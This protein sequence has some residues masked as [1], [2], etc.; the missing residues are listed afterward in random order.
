MSKLLT[1]LIA[2]SF[3]VGLNFAAAQN[4]DSDK[5]KAQGQEKVMQEKEQ[6]AQQNSSGAP[7]GQSDRERMRG[8]AAQ[9]GNPQNQSGQSSQGGRNAQYSRMTQECRSMSGADK[10]QCMT[11]AR[12]RYMSSAASRCGR[13]TDASMKQQCMDDVRAA[14]GGSQ[15]SGS[16]QSGQD[17]DSPK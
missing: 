14:I 3:G 5:D 8:D 1:A 9:P 15:M 10:D 13:M 17:Q 6:G 11:N 12:S 7:Q 2:A 16:D 4:V